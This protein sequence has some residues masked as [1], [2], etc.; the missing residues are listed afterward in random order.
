MKGFRS[1][2]FLICAFA[3]SLGETRGELFAM[4]EAP[5]L[6]QAGKSLIFEFEGCDLNPAWT[7]GTG[8][9]RR[10]MRP[11]RDLCPKQ[12]YSGIDGQIRKME[13]LWRGTSI[14][15]GMTH[16]RDAE[17]GLMLRP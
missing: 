5:A 3:I 16:R 7:D 2:F 17:A 4:P 1:L 11:I 8:G 12:D 9:G 10:E 6:N 14:E 15:R 13:R